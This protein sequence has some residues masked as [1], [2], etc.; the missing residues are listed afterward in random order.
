MLDLIILVAVC[1]LFGAPAFG[2][3]Q[4]REYVKAALIA[5][6]GMLVFQGIHIWPGIYTD[7]LWFQDVGYTARFW[8]LIL[9]KVSL[10]SIGGLVAA[11][12]GSVSVLTWNR[13][14][15]QANPEF[16]GHPGRRLIVKGGMLVQVGAFIVF[17]LGASVYWNELLLYANAVPFGKA[18]PVFNRDIGFYI[19]TLP[20]I[21]TLVGFAESVLL[22]SVVLSAG[23]Y[24]FEGLLFKTAELYEQFK[25]RQVISLA[26]LLDPFV[27]R[28]VTNLAVL[29]VPGALIV[30]VNT[31]V[32][33]WELL[34]SH[35][36][37][38]YGAGWTDINVQLPAY[39]VMIGVLG[40]C[41]A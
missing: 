27:H 33:R 12:F 21:K 37:V 41:A 39:N 4:R 9:V 28:I 15:A 35:R 6:A 10:F 1:L 20:F 16:M 24:F 31:M 29:S 30:M 38:V 34:Y 7:F 26:S 17:G 32:S 22:Y 13:Y 36:G 19:F 40:I 14:F 11:L 2:R 25:T 18:E 8:K 5:L 23:L 3:A